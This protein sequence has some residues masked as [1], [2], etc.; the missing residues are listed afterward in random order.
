MFNPADATA[1]VML[2]AL[3]V[4]VLLAGADFGAGVW[5]ML[6]FGPRRHEQRATIAR[7]IGP[8]WEVNHIW[9]IIVVVIFFTG[10][11]SAF[12]AVMTAMHVPL[13]IMLVGIVLRGAAFTFRAYDNTPMAERRWS[14]RFAIPS[15]LVPVLLGSVVGSLATGRIGSGGSRAFEPWYGVFPLLVGL[16]T[17]VI[18]AYLA[19]VY[20]TLE[21]DDLRLSNDFRHRALWAAC[22]LG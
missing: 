7:A 14:W 15:M 10:F 2:A 4:Y 16:F 1:L 11:P 19:A 6:A 18:V 17:L 3:T 9:I 21:T 5:D 13:S 22:V 12:A 8:V 20:L